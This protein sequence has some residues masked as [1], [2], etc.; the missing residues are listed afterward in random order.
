MAP[1]KTKSVEEYDVLPTQ[2][3]M[4]IEDFLDE[5]APQTS[6]VEIYQRKSD[7]SMPHQERVGTE[8]LRTDLYGYLRDKFGAGKF[9][10][11]FKDA[12]R[13][14]RKCLTVD[15]GAG[16][17]T[18]SNPTGAIGG[19]SHLQFM[20][21]Q[22]QMQQTLLTTLIASM[23]PPPALDIGAMMTGMG[24]MIGA[25]KPSASDPAA[26]L[27]AMAATFQQLKP[28]D[29]NVEKALSI[30]SKAKDI[31]GNGGGDGDSWAG[32][33]KEGVTAVAQAFK[34]PN[35]A[36]NP[37]PGIPPGAVPAQLNA[38]APATEKTQD[39][40]LQEWLDVELAFLKK[41]ALAGKDPEFWAD[42][43]LQNEE[44]PGS[45]AILQA[46]QRGAAFQ[47]L[48]AF[49]PEIGKNP[50]LAGWFQKFYEALHADLHEDMD[51]SGA[52]GDAPDP[53]GNAEPRP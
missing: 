34:Q 36:S 23:R 40:L 47:H 45:A 22:M 49:D 38:G 8:I 48:I 15:V 21:E 18:M 10:L 37:R 33:V 17:K 27:A 14:I 12:D 1:R 31:A 5:W 11:Q 13:K 24:A 39:E 3:E 9:I 6:V 16:E 28:A 46:L 19:D 26:M 43:I 4:D 20:R 52:G 35:A 30:I 42:Y 2:A 32:V 25:L 44:E 29:D 53:G 51:T 50:V 41:K 7:G